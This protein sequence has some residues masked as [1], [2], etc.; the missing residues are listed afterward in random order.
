MRQDLRRLRSATIGTPLAAVALATPPPSPSPDAK[1]AHKA[2]KR[3][4]K[5]NQTTCIRNV[6]SMKK[7]KKQCKKD[8]KKKKLCQKTCCELGFAV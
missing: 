3:K 1:C 6:R 4:C 2:D 8:K 7:C 5:I